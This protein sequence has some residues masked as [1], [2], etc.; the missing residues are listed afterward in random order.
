[1]VGNAVCPN[2]QLSWENREEDLLNYHIKD[3]PNLN[4]VESMNLPNVSTMF[5]VFISRIVE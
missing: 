2:T 1:M 4:S 5:T 3:G